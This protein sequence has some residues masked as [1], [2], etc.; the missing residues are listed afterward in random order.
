MHYKSLF[1]QVNYSS[2]ETDGVIGSPPSGAILPPDST[3]LV[4][5]GLTPNTQY[6]VSVVAFTSVGGSV[7][8]IEI[9]QTN[10]DGK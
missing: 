8:E 2:I 10:E 7:P 1:L 9:G 3:S 5:T 4:V 6:N